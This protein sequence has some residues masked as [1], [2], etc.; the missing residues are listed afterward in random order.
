MI[1]ENLQIQEPLGPKDPNDTVEEVTSFTKKTD[2]TCKS[3]ERKKKQTNM[4]LYFKNKSPRQK[5]APSFVKP[6]KAANT[7]YYFLGLIIVN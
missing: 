1:V 6:S 2:D 3:K 7:A 4:N 5:G